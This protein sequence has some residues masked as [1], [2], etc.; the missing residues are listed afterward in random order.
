MAN[1]MSP[2]PVWRLLVLNPAYRPEGAASAVNSKYPSPFVIAAET[3]AGV[4]APSTRESCA[5]SYRSRS[6]EKFIHT[7]LRHQTSW[8][9]QHS[10]ERDDEVRELPAA[11]RATAATVWVPFAALVVFHLTE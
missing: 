4:G 5:E 9:I 11:S 7:R 2:A 1:V 6:R 8:A 10:D 3:G